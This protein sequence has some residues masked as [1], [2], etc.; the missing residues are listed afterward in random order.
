MTAWARPWFECEEELVSEFFDALLCAMVKE[1]DDTLA[2]LA[3]NARRDPA[4]R[5]EIVIR[6]HIRPMIDATVIDV[7]DADA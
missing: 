4:E 3:E 6:R 1:T 7:S 5:V 2:A